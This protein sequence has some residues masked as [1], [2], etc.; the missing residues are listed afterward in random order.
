MNN[1]NGG[2]IV[3]II[4]N[5]LHFVKY[6]S[7]L[8]ELF[9]SKASEPLGLGEGGGWGLA[10]PSTCFAKLDLTIRLLAS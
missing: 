9:L 3:H 4:E 7:F 10:S 5:N 8:D 6:W 2:K 1:K